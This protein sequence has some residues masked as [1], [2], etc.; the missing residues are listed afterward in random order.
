LP[1]QQPNTP[2]DL[3]REQIIDSVDAS[4]ER[5]GIEYIDLLQIHWP[6]RYTGGAF[7]S[8]DF[9]PSQYEQ[10]ST[11]S[12]GSPPVPFEEQLAA[13]QELIQAGKVRYVGV[14]NE[15]PYGV[16]SM[17]ALAKQFPDLYPKIV[18][19]QNSYSLVVRKDYECGLAEACYHHNVAL[20]PYSPLAGGT[21]AGK[22]RTAGPVSFS[23][24]VL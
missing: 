8:P 21:L 7:G 15:T 13:L 4:L 18:S 1:R 11:G 12:G 9:S 20:L 16:C 23:L 14:S 2:A 22:Y 5:L 19:I 17:C 10:E 6:G 24:V 3:T